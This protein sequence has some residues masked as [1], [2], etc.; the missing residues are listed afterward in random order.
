MKL[1][2][3]AAIL[4]CLLLSLI[5][6]V[7]VA[8][9][10]QEDVK[11]RLRLLPVTAVEP[12][13]KPLK[14]LTKDDFELLVDGKPVPIRNVDE[15]D[16][17]TLRYQQQKGQPIDY[18]SADLPPRRIIL[19]FD[20]L[21]S[22]IKGY[23]D[24]PNDNEILPMRSAATREADG[25]QPDVERHRGIQMSKGA[26]RRWIENEMLPTDEV[27]IIQYFL[28][29]RMIQP[30]T[31]K[32]E[33]LMRAIE[34]ISIP[35]DTIGPEI[36]M[37]SDLAG[38]D[39][40]KFSRTEVQIAQMS[41]AYLGFYERL[42]E[43][44]ASL[45][46]TKNIIMFSEGVAIHQDIKGLSFLPELQRA[47]Q[48]LASA[49]S[50]IAAVSIAGVGRRRVNSYQDDFLFQMA[51]E[52]GGTY[53]PGRARL[54]NVL[55]EASESFDHFYE[56]FFSPTPKE[57]TG[58]H[59]VE[60]RLK[61]REAKVTAPP[62]YLGERNFDQLTGA[63]RDIHILQGFW[64]PLLNELGSELSWQ[65]LPYGKGRT[66]LHIRSFIPPDMLAEKD[67]TKFEAYLAIGRE[68]EKYDDARWEVDRKTVDGGAAQLDF[69]IPLPEGHSSFQFA[70][71]DREDGK[72]AYMMDGVE[73]GNPGKGISMSPVYITSP[74]D[75]PVEVNAKQ[76]QK[77][78]LLTGPIPD[79]VRELVNKPQVVYPMSGKQ[80][81]VSFIF[82]GPDF[83]QAAVEYSRDE[84][85]QVIE[86]TNLKQEPL[87]DDLRMVSFSVALP[88]W[89]AGEL[90]LKPLVADKGKVYALVPS[91]LTLN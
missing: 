50:R 89:E 44:L 52:T 60:V 8:Q 13:G 36:D 65:A 79:I 80:V 67:R 32:K 7:S 10:K 26:A 75:K 34:E 33:S 55:R 57:G 1:M 85:K 43:L 83:Q 39:T 45:P 90:T 25:P 74:E 88:Q 68:G 62:G 58:F 38:G 15:Y 64:Q 42:G 4:S 40:G 30:Y 81:V 28:G 5:T 41:K 91:Q 47:T 46:G 70:V 19:V 71:M 37:F 35:Q 69:L 73:I 66:A 53:Y 31:S 14:G 84:T 17:G 56:V 6:L 51:H 86:A 22:S 21:S 20:L 16:Y 61:S 49:N 24:S 23:Q 48:T 2:F 54:D 27:A 76:T 87:A 72:R 11:V 82:Q 9:E 29:A 12:D 63:Q 3:K 59:S 18:E 77:P 78:E